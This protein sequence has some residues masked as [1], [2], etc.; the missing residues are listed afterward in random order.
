MSAVTKTL[1][2]LVFALSVAF[3]AMQVVLYGKRDNYGTA[4]VETSKKLSA[5]VKKTQD[6]QK[7]LADLKRSSDMDKDRLETANDQLAEQKSTADLRIKELDLQNGKLA[8]AVEGANDTVTALEGNIQTRD[9]NI[10]NLKKIIVERDAAIK[11]HLARITALDTTVAE[12][13][14]TIGKL[15]H[16][17][18][19]TKKTLV[20]TKASEEDLLAIISNLRKRGVEIQPVALPI[21]NGQVVRVNS[22]Y[23]A[24][25]VDKGAKDGV[26]PNTTFTIY[27][28]TN[29]IARLIIQDVQPESSVGMITLV[30][31]REVK[32]G[33][34]AT[35][36]IP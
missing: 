17:L 26:K 14:A 33:D 31:G 25:V 6:L 9:Q 4:Y 3:A 35:T 29:Y 12:R 36:E 23:G 2:V 5:E 15:D 32:E 1:V 34:K 21:V 7:E 8:A 24:A 30:A 27:D 10:E 28:G 13:D 11:E 22:E 20:A 16:D 19:E 18:T